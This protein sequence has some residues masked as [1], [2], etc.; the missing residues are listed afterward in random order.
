MFPCPP[1][2]PRRQAE[3]ASEGILW[4]FVDFPDN[5]QTLELLEAKRVGVVALL[6][7]QCV[8]ISRATDRGGEEMARGHLQALLKR[9]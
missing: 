5:R 8:L 4:S 7:E 2:A 9:I 3:Y 1:P 6:D